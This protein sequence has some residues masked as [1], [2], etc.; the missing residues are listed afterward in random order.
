MATIGKESCFDRVACTLGFCPVTEESASVDG[1]F[2]FMATSAI[3]E[4][5][6]ENPQSRPSEKGEAEFGPSPRSVFFAF[7]TLARS[8]STSPGIGRVYRYPLA[9]LR[10]P[11]QGIVAGSKGS[12]PRDSEASEKR[13]ACFSN[14]CWSKPHPF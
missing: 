12:L 4:G 13:K 2:F 7:S 11:K 14:S 1:R 8:V 10:C 9:E 6:R 3:S 5:P